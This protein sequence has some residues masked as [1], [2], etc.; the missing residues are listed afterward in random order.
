[1]SLLDVKDLRV[2]FSTQGYCHR[3]ERSQFLS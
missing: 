2:E 1:M 3:S